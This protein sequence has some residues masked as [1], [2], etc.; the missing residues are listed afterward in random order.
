MTINSKIP[1]FYATLGKNSEGCQELS[2]IATHHKKVHYLALQ[3]YYSSSTV[4]LFSSIV[5]CPHCPQSP[6]ST[7]NLNNFGFMYLFSKFFFPPR[8]YHLDASTIKISENHD[9][10]WHQHKLPK[11]QI[12]PSRSLG[13]LGVKVARR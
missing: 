4:A 11:I 12:I 10:I 7:S 1:N 2:H 8:S 6:L 3:W 13:L 5:T 9:L